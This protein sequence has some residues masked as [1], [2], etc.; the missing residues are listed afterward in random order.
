MSLAKAEADPLK[1]YDQLLAARQIVTRLVTEFPGS[2]AAVRISANDKIGP[3]TLADLNTLVTALAQRPELC[4]RALTR[5]CLTDM[6]LSNLDMLLKTDRTA[7]PDPAVV[8]L[9]FV[10]L[11]FANLVAQDRVNALFEATLDSKGANAELMARS[12]G[13]PATT[14][15]LLRMIATVRGE[16]ALTKAIASL[17]AIPGFR[18]AAIKEFNRFGFIFLNARTP[19]SAKLLTAAAHALQTPLPEALSAALEKQICSLGTDADK[20]AIV[21]TDCPLEA[22]LKHNTSFSW[23]PADAYDRLYEAATTPKQKEDIASSALN[24]SFGDLDHKL[25][26][27]GRTKTGTSLHSLANLYVE[28][29]K[30]GNRA[31]NT[32]IS[33][34]EAA[35]DDQQDNHRLTEAGVTWKNVLLLHANGSLAK[36]L[37]AIVENIEAQPQFSNQLHQILHTLV[38]L[39]PITPGIDQDAI[40]NLAGRIIT[41]WP[42][43]KDA[44]RNAIRAAAINPLSPDADPK[45]AYDVL[46]AGTPYHDGLGAETAL[47]FKAHGHTNIFDKAIAAS[48]P[49]EEVRSLRYGL[50]EKEIRDL[51]AAGDITTMLARIDALPEMTR[52]FV[53]GG[54][55]LPDT[56]A[57]TQATRDA[58]RASLYEKYAFEIAAYENGWNKDLGLP[59]STRLETISRDYAKIQ[60]L[61]GQ[62]PTSWLVNGFADLTPEQRLKALHTLH[63]A[64][65][66]IWP[67]YASGIAM[68]DHPQ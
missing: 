58:I 41:A 56:R 6:V 8:K 28:A 48:K 1:Q 64:N 22:L 29:T 44:Y 55:L 40:F 39:Q 33:E 38:R 32:L 65:D 16:D 5:E 61:T 7:K 9:A 30:Q 11:P 19:Q 20:N 59:V 43:D 47:S 26:W 27:H 45:P 18:D 52:Y 63:A 10:G 53:I 66:E 51:A 57:V 24:S 34:I 49:I 3:Y 62:A 50:M 42:K 4:L 15:I 21:L 25:L 13:F 14:P 2:S 17:T 46:F 36:Q 37:P 60:K 68:V 31:R 67:I 12:F 54:L 23:L 35:T